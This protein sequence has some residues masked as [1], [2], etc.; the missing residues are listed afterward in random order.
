[1]RRKLKKY[2]IIFFKQKG[3]LK[4]MKKWRITRENTD[5]ICKFNYLRLMIKLRKLEEITNTCVTK[6]VT[7]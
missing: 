4:A 1:L 5:A 3:K 6:F 2:E 7:I